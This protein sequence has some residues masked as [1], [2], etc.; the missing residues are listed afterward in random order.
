MNDE[1][2][3]KMRRSP[4]PEFAEALYKRISQQRRSMMFEYLKASPIR[5]LAW[6]MALLGLLLTTALAALPGARAM[7]LRVT[8]QIG[9]ITFEETDQYPGGN[10]SEI[11]TLAAQQVGLSKVQA[12]IPFT[13]TLPT[14]VPDGFELQEEVQVIL[15]TEISRHTSVSLQWCPVGRSYNCIHMIAECPVGAVPPSSLVVGPGNVEEVEINGQPAALV[16]GAWNADSQR[17]DP[18]LQL[19]LMWEQ[20]GVTYSLFALDVQAEDLI[21]MAE[22]I[23]VVETD[24]C[25]AAQTSYPEPTPMIITEAQALVPFKL[26]SWTPEG[27]VLEDEVLMTEPVDGEDAAGAMLVWSKAGTDAHIFLHAVAGHARWGLADAEEITINGQPAALAHGEF[28]VLVLAQPRDYPLALQWRQEGVLYT[29]IGGEGG[30]TRDD[31]IRM[32]ESVP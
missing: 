28:R 19:S 9:R 22:S 29:L 3:Y 5:A 14:W 23:P 15:P 21:R 20:G 16:H 17:Y 32:A 11:P 26:P 1:F 13:L 2:L 30:V 25:A 4:R 27:F 8:K 31:L 10:L 7:I 24:Q 12:M 18:G 6:G